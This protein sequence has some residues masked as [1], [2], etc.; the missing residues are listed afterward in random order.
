[1]NANISDGDRRTYAG[2]EICEIQ[3]VILGGSP[4]EPSNKTVL[5]REQH[6]KVVVYWN[7]EIRRLRAEQQTSKRG[8]S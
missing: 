2:K 8:R 5:P 4:T 6:I 1:M 7:R 3:P